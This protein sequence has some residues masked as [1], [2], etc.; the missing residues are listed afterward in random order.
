MRI[1]LFYLFF[2]FTLLTQTHAQSSLSYDIFTCKPPAGYTLKEKQQKL[3]YEKIQGSNYC[4]LYLWPAI[5]GNSDNNKDFLR[6]WE[7]FAS[8]PYRVTKPEQLNQTT[9][10]G[11]TVSNGGAR[12]QYNNI[13]F[14]I[15]ISTYTSGDVTYA[16]VAVL[17][18]SK[19]LPD[20]NAFIASVIPDTR[21]FNRLNNNP[22]NNLQ[23]GISKPTTRFDD[24][25]L[26]S[27][28]SEYVQA[29]RNSTEI[30]L[31]YINSQLDDAKSNMIDAPEYYWSQ[32]VAPNFNIPRPE[33]WS[34]VQYPVIYYM[35][36]S[37]TDK[38]TGKSCFVALKIV[39]EGGARPILVI[40]PDERTFRQ[41]F[42]HPNDL[43]RMQVCNKF[44]ITLKDVTGTWKGSG[45]GG[46][47][48]YNVYSGQFTG[49]ST[50]SVSDE[51]TFNA[52]G[53]YSSTYRSASTNNGGASFGGQDFSGKFS[54]SDWTLT[55][56]NRYRGKTTTF[57]AQLI[58]ARGGYLLYLSDRDNPSMKYTLFKSK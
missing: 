9:A 20:V 1:T 24:G 4:Q 14:V 22:S 57:N 49:A 58:A 46:V 40:T 15:S 41:Q 27:A 8:K 33:K 51:F 29:T 28:L 47:E 5:Q 11:W 30:R 26:S 18:D 45:G 52:N 50:I 37:G 13:S 19:F 36:G 54:V 55:A 34:G 43:D 44:A 25:W 31:Y 32:Y 42:T 16:I 39:Y 6:D 56:T 7:S 35:E 2:C 23:T 3:F 48:Y 12:G 17:N 21:K 10:G 38:K 53:N